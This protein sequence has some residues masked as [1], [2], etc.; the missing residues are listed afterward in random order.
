MSEARPQSNVV[1]KSTLTIESTPDR[2]I[3]TRNDHDLTS[4]AFLLLIGFLG[5]AACAL[6]GTLTGTI[7]CIGVAFLILLVFGLIAAAQAGLAIVGGRG[8]L[9]LSISTEG[10]EKRLRNQPDSAVRGRAPALLTLTPLLGTHTPYRG[11]EDNRWRRQ[12]LLS[13][14]SVLDGPIDH[15]TLDADELN[16]LQKALA[17]LGPGIAELGNPELGLER[18]VTACPAGGD[19]L[20]GIAQPRCPECG[21]PISPDNLKHLEAL[22]AQARQP[23]R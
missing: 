7:A 13:I 9:T 5:F 2:L 12:W 19:D 10:V 22:A 8:V 16:Q 6:M 14:A 20:I 4:G 3:I 15:I 21:R 17:V 23:L 18:W 1:R 11:E